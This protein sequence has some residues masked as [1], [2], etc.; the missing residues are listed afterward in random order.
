MAELIQ[1]SDTLNQGREKLNE[2]ITDANKAKVDAG[3]AVSTSNQARQIAQ[4]AENKADSVQ[5]Q[6]DQVVIEGDSSVEAAQARVTAV[7]KTYPTLQSRLNDT[8]AQLA[9][10]AVYPQDFG[11]LGDGT[12]ESSKLQMAFDYLDSKGGGKL[13]LGDGV[14]GYMD[15]LHIKE[16]TRLEVS[17]GGSFKC[18]NDSARLIIYNDVQITNLSCTFPSTYQGSAIWFDNAYLT[19]RNKRDTSKENAKVFLERVRLYKPYNP[20]YESVGLKLFANRQTTFTDIAG[21]WGVNTNDVFI[22]GFTKMIDFETVLTGWVTGCY[23]FKITGDNLKHAVTMQ[24]SSE[25]LG[26]SKNVFK[27]ITIQ[28]RG[29]TRE[30]FNDDSLFNTYTDI[31]IWDMMFHPDAKQGTALLKNN[32]NGRSYNKERLLWTISPNR[33]Y[34]LGT[35]TQFSSDAHHVMISV[36]G[37]KN[38]YTKFYIGGDG[39]IEVRSYGRRHFNSYF[40][41]YKKDIGGGK[42]ELYMRSTTDKGL[43]IFFESF[44]S[45][46]PINENVSYESVTGLTQLTDTINYDYAYSDDIVF[47]DVTLQNGWSGKLECGENGLGQTI[48]QGQITAGTITNGTTIG[49]LASRYRPKYAKAIDVYDSYRGV[50]YTGITINTS[51]TIVIR[52]PAATELNTNSTISINT[53]FQSV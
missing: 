37:E 41:F 13:I 12:D 32:V 16:G 25:S 8:D 51:G 40:S 34:L 10:I 7:G 17:N 42:V 48:L 21:F 31:T 35:F 11:I 33:Y 46:A 19:N 5:A 14:Y 9:E 26:I 22:D 4:T 20:T 1:K 29:V 39:I 18:L 3:Q 28:C 45:F 2:A 6:F 23:F 49:Q 38:Y 44:R 50:C 47:V 43:N 30:L 24:K 27:D 52:P 36:N 53:T 15:D